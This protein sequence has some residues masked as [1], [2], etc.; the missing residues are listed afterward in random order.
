VVPPCIDA[1]PH[2]ILT[3]CYFGVEGP[4]LEGFA[5]NSRELEG[6]GVYTSE[7]VSSRNGLS[8]SSL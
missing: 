8:H 1:N 2:K 5:F 7:A 6:K 4:Y 3:L